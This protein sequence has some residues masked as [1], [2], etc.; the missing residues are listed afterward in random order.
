[1]AQIMKRTLEAKLL[2]IKPLNK[3]TITDITE[4]C[5]INRSDVLLGCSKLCVP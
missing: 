4:D 1:M 5:G 3:I 2:R